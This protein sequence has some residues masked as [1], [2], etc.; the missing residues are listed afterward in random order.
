M[1]RVLGILSVSLVLAGCGLS[2]PVQLPD[3]RTY[4]LS[5][6]SPTKGAS[7]HRSAKT[8]LVSLPIPD[9]GYASNAMVYELVPFDLRYYADNQWAAPPAQM[10]MPLMAQ[11]LA[12]QGYFKGVVTTPFSG[13][14][15][16]RL[17]TRLIALK[18]SFLQPTSREVLTLQETLTS[19]ATNEVLASR[20]FNF[21]VPAPRNNAYSGVV[22][23]NR[24]ARTV[25]NQVA[26]WVVQRV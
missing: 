10:L 25:A 17:D 3:Q 8:I 4:T 21:V 2:T 14:T 1:K 24:A 15:S 20:R 13:I 16:Y 11:A 18:Q 23:A 6:V 5:S 9:P 22:A 7:Q 19:N 26:R 12:N